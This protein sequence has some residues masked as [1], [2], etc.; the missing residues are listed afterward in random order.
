MASDSYYVCGD[1]I[2]VES[3]QVRLRLTAVDSSGVLLFEDN[4]G[5][6]HN[7]TAEKI[8]RLSRDNLL[9]EKAKADDASNPIFD[10]LRSLSKLRSENDFAEGI[11]EKISDAGRRLFRAA[12][13]DINA[14]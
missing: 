4:G 11:D 3:S 10:E 1:E 14:R 12:V 8:N 5:N 2:G 13:Q 9:I 6:T 7:L